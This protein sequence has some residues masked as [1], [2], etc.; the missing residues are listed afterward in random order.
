MNNTND[1]TLPVI[2]IMGPTASGKTG[3]SIE[4]AKRIPSEIISVDSA[5]IYKDMDI[6]TAKPDE[7][8]QSGIPHHLIDI[9][10]PEQTYSV[11]EFVADCVSIIKQIQD[12]GK[13]PILV[14]GTMMYFNALIK[15]L[16]DLPATDEDV[17]QNVK[18]LINDKGLAHVH[19]LMSQADPDA[20][21]RIHSNDLQRT[22]RAYEVFL[23]TGKPLTFWQNQ[24]K[25]GYSGKIHQ[26]SI[27]PEDRAILHERIA[28]RFDLMLKNGFIEEVELLLKNY[29]LNPEMPSLRSVGYRQVYD[30]L[31][32]NLTREGMQDRGVIA[33]RQLAKRQVTW[34]RGWSDLINLYTNDKNNI[35]VVLKKT[36]V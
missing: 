12:R 13:V 36:G 23:A 11:S 26:F 30:F 3:L 34:L 14:G 7:E 8:E 16:S 20:G 25:P 18:A 1:S 15:G 9:R 10:T 24:K 21:A 35:D 31:E 27:M 32:G 19:S 22:S 33:T 6:G 28:M 5:L 29:N 2:S 4:L 17:R